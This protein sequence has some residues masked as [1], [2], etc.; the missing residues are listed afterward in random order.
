[1]VFL[2]RTTAA[3]TVLLQPANPS[4]GTGQNKCYNGRQ[5][6]LPPAASPVGF[7]ATGQPICWYRGKPMLQPASASTGD[8][9]LRRQRRPYFFATTD[10]V[11]ART[12]ER[13]CCYRLRRLFLAGGFLLRGRRG[14]FFLLHPFFDFGWNRHLLMWDMA[15]GMG[16]CKPA[17][18]VA[19]EDAQP[20]RR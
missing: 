16:C 7:A 5:R 15:E 19:G 13:G 14:G 4:A 1:M 2:I 3:M 12:R 11:D 9:V 6:Q 20:C 17:P 8:D 18:I 10:V